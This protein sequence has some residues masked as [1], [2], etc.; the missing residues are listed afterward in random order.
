MR[1]FRRA[2]KKFAKA[3]YPQQYGRRRPGGG[4]FRRT[5]V[6]DQDIEAYLGQKGKG[7]R[8]GSGKGH[9]RKG[10]PRGKDGKIMKCRICESEEHFAAKCPQNR[11]GKGGGAVPPPPTM[12]TMLN[13]PATGGQQAEGSAWP[14]FWHMLAQA[15]EPQ[16]QAPEDE[17][18]LSS[19]LNSVNDGDQNV[20]VVSGAA[21]PL[22]PRRSLDS[23]C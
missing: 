15:D 1:K 20:Y 6:T 22:E 9:G 10:N 13:D 12:S 7:G 2:V 19:L 14:M 21:R 3:R 18:P 23:T 8:K 5:Y 11:G 17:G 16:P 4:G